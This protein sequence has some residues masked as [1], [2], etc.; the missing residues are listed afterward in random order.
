LKHNEE[1]D[2]EHLL[3]RVSLDLTGLPPT[4]EQ[5]DK[6]VSDNSPQLM[7]KMVEALMANSTVWRENGSSLA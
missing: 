7:K 2:K 6:F 3:K 4:P 1:A 5:I